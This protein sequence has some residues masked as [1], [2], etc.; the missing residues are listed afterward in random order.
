ML[1]VGDLLVLLWGCGVVGDVAAGDG[2]GV[3]VYGGGVRRWWQAD[4]SG[5]RVGAV[6]VLVLMVMIAML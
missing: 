5:A 3:G 6:V 2:V 1:L 4:L